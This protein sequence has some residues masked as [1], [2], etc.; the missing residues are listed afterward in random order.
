MRDRVQ[1]RPEPEE[2]PERNRIIAVNGIKGDGFGIEGHI[3]SQTKLPGVALNQIPHP[4]ESVG[5]NPK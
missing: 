5:P 1:G 3:A 2:Y 4:A